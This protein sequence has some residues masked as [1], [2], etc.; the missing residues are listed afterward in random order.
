MFSAST[1]RDVLNRGTSVSHERYE[2]TKIPQGIGRII[3]IWVISSGRRPAQSLEDP[4]EELVAGEYI[5]S[6]GP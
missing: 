2:S 6:D 4:S 1:T 3:F 5:C